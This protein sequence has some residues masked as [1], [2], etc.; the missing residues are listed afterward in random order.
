METLKRRGG[1]ALMIA[2][3]GV[4]LTCVASTRVSALDSKEVV[5]RDFVKRVLKGEYESTATMLDAKMK[6]V[7]SASQLEQ[8]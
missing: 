1:T 3:I 8:F 2:C 6:S 4:L 5:G 7:M